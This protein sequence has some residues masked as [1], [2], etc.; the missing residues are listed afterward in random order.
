VTYCVPKG[1]NPIEFANYLNEIVNSITKSTFYERVAN[2]YSLLKIFDYRTVAQQYIDLA[3]N[4]NSAQFLMKAK[5]TLSPKI[6][7]DAM[8]TIGFF[9]GSV[10]V[11]R[12]SNNNSVETLS[13]FS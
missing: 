6:K 5:G 4:Y 11:G 3:F 1:D 13:L 2:N 8:R 9:D 7:K 12:K 10:E